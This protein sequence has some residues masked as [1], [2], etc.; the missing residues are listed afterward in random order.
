MTENEAALEETVASIK[1]ELENVE[2]LRTEIVAELAREQRNVRVLGSILHD[3]YNSC[4]RIFKRIC[5]EL[6]GGL[7]QSDR[8]HKELLYRMTIA[9]EDLRPIVISE[10]LAAELDDYLSFRHVFRNI[11]GFELKGE[12]LMR[13][14]EKFDRVSLQLIDE[15]RAFL[16]EIEV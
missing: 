10:E 7:Y 11:Y 4:E 5:S 6:N 3:F 16:A 8:W 12:R 1:K 9:V 13:L 15:V 2:G 14:A